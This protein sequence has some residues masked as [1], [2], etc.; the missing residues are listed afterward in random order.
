MKVLKDDP[1]EGARLIATVARAVHYAHQR[2]ILHR[3]LKPGNILMDSAGEPHV[4]DFGLAKRLDA[5]ASM[6]P[7]VGAVG[8]AAYMAPEQARGERALTTAA[9]VYSLGS[10]LY[11]ILVGHPPFPG[12]NALDVMQRL[13]SQPVPAPHSL[14]PDVD[15]T[16]EAICLK[17]LEKD[18]RRRYPTALALAEEIERYL[19][20]ER[21]TV[22]HPGMWDW[23]RQELRNRPQPSAYTWSILVRCGLILLAMHAGIFV[24]V[25]LGLQAWKVW[26]VLLAGWIAFGGVVMRHAASRFRLLH[27]AERQTSMIAVGHL[28]TD[29]L[30]YLMVFGSA[31]LTGPPDRVL[32]WYPPLALLSGFG[33]FIL[34]TTH[35]G[36]FY[37]IGVGMMLLCGPMIWWPRAAPLIFGFSIALVLL[38]WAYALRVMFTTSP[39]A[40]ATS[41]DFVVPHQ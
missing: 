14:N 11:E 40:I 19:R 10:I 1:R 27:A 30:L 17:C 34:G 9:D 21:V 29:V 38:W 8:T 31:P 36:R 4:T 15:R 13:V 28:L 18:P 6:S 33:L 3:D 23:L 25:E 26:A 35:W 7:T 20:G 5:E 39:S 41:P 12:P 37:V 22:Q 24:V 16:L 2:G 32:D